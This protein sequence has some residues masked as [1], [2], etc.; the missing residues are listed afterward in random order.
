MLPSQSYSTQAQVRSAKQAFGSLVDSMIYV[1]RTRELER[2]IEET[3]EQAEKRLIALETF[4]VDVSDN[5]SKLKQV[6]GEARTAELA[7]Q[8]VGFSSTAV[9][10]MKQKVNLENQSQISLLESDAK[11]EKTKAIKSLEAF[12]ST[13]PLPIIDRAIEVNLQDG[14]Y[15]SKVRY[16]CL[17]N[18]EYE[19]ALD[20]RYNPYFKAQCLVGTL[21]RTLRVPVALGKS[22]LKREPVPDIRSLEQFIIT[23]VE[24]TETSLIVQCSDQ[25]GQS[26]VRIVYTR[27]GDH[28]S[29]SVFFTANGATVDITSE[30]GLNAHLSSDSFSRVMER[31]WLATNDLEKRRITIT[32]LIFENHS[33][34][35]NMD[36][37]EFFLKCWGAIS[38]SVRETMRLSSEKR[39]SFDE[40]LDRPYVKERLKALGPEAVEIADLI[41]V[42][43]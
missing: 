38:E 28:V 1:Q 8:I 4:K 33:L 26:E 30:P 41:A 13:S 7:K 21:D 23:R 3:T 9:D 6:L 24:A 15:A 19:F 34:L 29:L 43:L 25:D 10:Q 36:S 18:I 17:D 20:T 31:I 32:K 37:K 39:V 35:E 16:R 11:S 27:S 12:L 22:W 2:K 14:A 42:E 5:I 40:T